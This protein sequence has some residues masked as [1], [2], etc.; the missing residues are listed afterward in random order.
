MAPLILMILGFIWWWPRTRL[1]KKLPQPCM[2]PTKRTTSLPVTVPANL[3]SLHFKGRLAIITFT[4]G[5]GRHW[6][7]ARTRARHRIDAQAVSWTKPTCASSQIIARK[8]LSSRAL[9]NAQPPVVPQKTVRQYRAT[10][11]TP[12]I[13]ESRRCD[14]LVSPIRS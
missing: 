14:A 8:C 5:W 11:E 2:T 12:A 6:I 7:W 9:G 4:P 10:L 3:L 1:S 13:G